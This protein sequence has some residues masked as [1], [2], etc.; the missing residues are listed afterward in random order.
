MKKISKFEVPPV[1][2][3]KKADNCTEVQPG[4]QRRGG[5]RLSLSVRPSWEEMTAVTIRP[6]L[7]FVPSQGLR[8]R[9]PEKQSREVL[10]GRRVTSTDMPDS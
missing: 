2:R 9:A 5:S 8:Q 1:I 7:T 3:L 10:A 6:P 4:Y